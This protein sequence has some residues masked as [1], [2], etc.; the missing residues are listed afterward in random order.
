MFCHWERFQEVQRIYKKANG[1]KRNSW[2]T[3]C[4]STEIAS[5][6]SRSHRILS[7]E[8]ND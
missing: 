5:E 7:K 3:F 2:K 6:A 1:T 4:E 8:T